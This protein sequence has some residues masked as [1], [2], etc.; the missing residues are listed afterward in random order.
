VTNPIRVKRLVWAFLDSECEEPELDGEICLA[1][2]LIEARDT[3]PMF[4][5]CSLVAR[6]VGLSEEVGT[7]VT[8][9]SRH[10]KDRTR[11][12]IEVN[13]DN[14][15]P[16]RDCVF[17]VPGS[18]STRW[19]NVWALTLSLP[20]IDKRLLARLLCSRERPAREFAIKRILPLIKEQEARDKPS[21]EV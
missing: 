11:L 13:E 2:L 9:V 17:Y 19:G 14:L 15:D 8:L 18:A 16:F 3:L 7:K 20:V 12:I 5:S 6:S 4:S 10:P 21:A 1:Y